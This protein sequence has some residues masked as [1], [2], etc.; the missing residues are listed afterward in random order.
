MD[1]QQKKRAGIYIHIPF[2]V[3][4]CPYCD[5]YSITDLSLK[6][7]FL[8]ALIREMELFQSGSLNFDTIYLGGGT[9]SVLDFDDIF[10]I[11]KGALEIFNILPA[12]EITLEINPGTVTRTLLNAYLRAGINRLN[13]GAQSFQEANLNF[14]GRIHSVK[15]AKLAF[16]E[17][18]QSGFENIGLDLIYGLPQQTKENLRADLENAVQ[19]GPDHLACYLLTCEPGTPLHQDLQSGRYRPLHDLKVRELFDL[20][21][22][23]LETH[24]YIQYEISNFARRTDETSPPLMSRHNLKYWSFAPYAGFGPSAHSFIQPERYWNY[25]D[26]KKYSDE[27]EAGRLPVEEKEVLT[28]EQLMMETIYLGL[29]TIQGIDLIEFNQRFTVDFLHTFDRIVTDLE[30]D[31]LLRMAQNH[32][33]LTRKGLAYHDS[34]VSMF[35]G[36]DVNFQ[37]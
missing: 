34:V 24:G 13:I 3:K 18:R 20:T 15:D 1:F 36:Q 4:K 29:R 27:I 11:I 17:A 6:P 10:L 30:T 21:I 7:G 31:G 32:C 28:T 37:C 8:Q 12:P 22:D 25:A 16:E 35:T 5:F 26:V 2:C 23:Y 19:L 33:A 9:P 14:L